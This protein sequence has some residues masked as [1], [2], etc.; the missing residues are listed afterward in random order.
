[1]FGRYPLTL[2]PQLAGLSAQ[3]FML[4][5]LLHRQADLSGWAVV[6]LPT[7]LLN[8]CQLNRK[9]VSRALQQLETARLVRV[10][11]HIGRRSTVTVLWHPQHDL[12]VTGAEDWR[13]G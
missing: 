9:A 1:M 2:L 12:C 10:H 13:D 3:A 8:L 7:A 6:R 11:R 5:L 4:A